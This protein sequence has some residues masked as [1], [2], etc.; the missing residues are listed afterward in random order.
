MAILSRR[1]AVTLG[2]L[3]HGPRQ[4][5]VATERV[6][7]QERQRELL[8]DLE[9]RLAAAVGEAVLVLHRHDVGDRTGLGQLVDVDVGHSQLFD[10]AVAL[11][12][13]QRAERFGERHRWVDRVQLDQSEAVAA[14]PRQAALDGLAQVLGPAVRCPLPGSPDDQNPAF[15]A[16]SRSS[17]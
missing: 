16:I 15:V 9:H 14:Q 13:D 7:G 10:L 1:G 12:L 17:G 8:A 3:L 11:E 6:P 5:A 2:H 4:L